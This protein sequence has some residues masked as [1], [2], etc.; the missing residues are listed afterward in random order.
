MADCFNC[1]HRQ[2]C[3]T[4]LTNENCA[5]EVVAYGCDHYNVENYIEP[6][7]ELYTMANAVHLFGVVNPNRSP[8]MA[9][10]IKAYARKVFGIDT[11]QWPEV[12]K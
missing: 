9:R 10:V 6:M 1:S 11:S 5:Q 3:N 7:I 8:A 4:Y 12:N 2:V